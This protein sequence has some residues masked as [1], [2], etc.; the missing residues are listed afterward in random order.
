[1]NTPVVRIGIDRRGDRYYAARVESGTGRVQIKALFRFDD[2]PMEDHQLFEGGQIAVAVPDS[3]VIVKKLRLD[4]EPADF[5]LRAG[6]ELSQ[7]LME[8]ERNL[9]V[10]S[11]DTGRSGQFLGLA[12]RREVFQR[13]TLQTLGHHFNGT[14]E[15]EGRMRAAALAD[16]YLKFCKPVGG[17]LI[18]LVDFCGPEI[19][20]VFLF[21]SKVVD[22]SHVLSNKFDLSTPQGLEKAAIE[23]KTIINF[24]MA[25]FFHDGISLP[26]STLIVIGDG[27]DDT[28]RKLLE[29]YFPTD[30]RSAEI[31]TGFL[32]ESYNAGAVPIEKYLVSLGLAAN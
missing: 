23:L 3:Q 16:G 10:D 27:I 20:L 31:N 11:I 17:E 28:A 15:V 24:K 29:P 26:L 21:R 9:L 8:D 32:P 14:K 1:M 19:S 7:L 6:F 5:R 25:S 30:V 12:I 4:T 22:L 18:G 2:S 13:A